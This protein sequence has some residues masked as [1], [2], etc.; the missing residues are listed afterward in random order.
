MDR[1]SVRRCFLSRPT[2]KTRS[3]LP[4][5]LGGESS[6]AQEQASWIA[7]GTMLEVPTVFPLQVPPGVPQFLPWALL[8]Q[9]RS[10]GTVVGSGKATK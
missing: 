3:A 1:T 7:G 2:P 5:S 10:L 9:G 6:F 4:G 8:L